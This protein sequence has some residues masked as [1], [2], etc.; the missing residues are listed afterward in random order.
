[1]SEMYYN[2]IISDKLKKLLLPDGG[3]YWLYS[4]VRKRDDL[5]FLIGANKSKKWI[6][7]YRGTTRLLDISMKKSKVNISANRKYLDMAKNNDLN[8]FGIKE[9]TELNFEDDFVILISLVMQDPKLKKHYDNKKEGFYQNLFSRQ[10]GILSKGDEDFVVVDKEVVIGYENKKSKKEHFGVQQ[11][12]YRTINE[13]LSIL[14]AKRY[15]SNLGKKVLGN[16][17]DFLAVNKQG[18]ILIIE[19]KHGS[20]TKGIYLSPI[21]IGLY[22]S[23]FQ[24]YIGQYETTFISHINDMVKQK[25][26]MGLISHK[27]P[28]VI[29]SGK[30]IPVLVIADYNQKSSGLPKF[31]K[32]LQE[33]RDRMGDSFLA[34]LRVFDYNESGQLNPL[35]FKINEP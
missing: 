18:D 11:D 29:L 4:L 23:L 19:F 27:W 24:E 16:E 1:M 26:E 33:C 28:D 34:D 7:V 15:G 2:R 13:A 20:S 9:I 8:I 5:D 25:K 35:S 32:V 30:I 12:K 21:Q 14:D 10:F 17:L 31:K 22:R 6:Y 3:L